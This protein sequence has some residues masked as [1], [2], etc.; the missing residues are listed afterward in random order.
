MRANGP[1][2]SSK[3]KTVSLRTERVKR[4]G[5]KTPEQ[6][7]R[8]FPATRSRRNR[9]ADWSRRLVRETSL[10][11]DDLIWPIFLIEGQKKR[12]AIESMPGVER[13]SIDLA[14]A[15]AREAVSLGLPAIALFPYT[16]PSLRDEQA[17]E[18]LNPPISF[19]GPCARSRR[20]CLRSASSAMSRSTP[21]RPTAMTGSSSRARSTTTAPWRCWWP[22]RSSRPKRAATFSRPRT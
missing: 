21:I 12:D 14:V 19:A 6:S 7:H 13:L 8:G 2:S 11:V 20:R 3:D 5:T 15:A 10:S 16:D 4:A 22:R 17:S 1:V 18:A 9:R